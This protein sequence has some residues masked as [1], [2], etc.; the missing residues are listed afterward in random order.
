M[1]PSAVSPERSSSKENEDEEKKKCELAYVATQET[2]ST[3]KK[4]GSVVGV[5]RGDDV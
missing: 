3:K 4:T 5:E 1:V 2:E